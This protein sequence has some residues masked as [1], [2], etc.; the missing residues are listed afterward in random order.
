MQT[1][2]FGLLLKTSS[3]APLLDES[4]SVLNLQGNSHCQSI[5]FGQAEEEDTLGSTSSVG[6]HVLFVRS[7]TVV[8]RPN[9]FGSGPGY[10]PCTRADADPKT[11]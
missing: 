4:S 2:Y 8:L 3:F 7:F 10:T 1:K 11:E 5:V 6:P 9:D